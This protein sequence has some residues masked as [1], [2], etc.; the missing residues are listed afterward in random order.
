VSLHRSRIALVTADGPLTFEELG[1]RADCACEH[2][3]QRE[4]WKVGRCVALPWA[5]PVTD[6]PALIGLWL[7]GGVWLA[8]DPQRGD[9]KRLRAF[10]RDVAGPSAGAGLWHSILFSSGSTGTPKLIVR[11]LAAS[12]S[13]G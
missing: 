6:L 5:T 11:V 7:A 3:K 4:N 8:Q 12:P 13:G 2:F 9:V 1:H 10:E